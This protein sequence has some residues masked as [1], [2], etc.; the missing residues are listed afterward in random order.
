MFDAT[1]WRRLGPFAVA[2]F[3]ASEASLIRAAELDEVRIP[4]M[5]QWCLARPAAIADLADP[6]FQQTEIGQVMLAIGKAGATVGVTQF[7]VPYGDHVDKVDDNNVRITYCTNINTSAQ[8]P[9]GTDISPRTR[10]ALSVVG[11]SCDGETIDS[12]E[13]ELV[14][15]VEGD[16]WKISP[17]D[18][19]NLQHFVGTAPAMGPLEARVVAAVNDANSHLYDAQIGLVIVTPVTDPQSTILALGLP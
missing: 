13:D 1:L 6:S 14:A 4:A 9:M 12:C 3:I 17:S 11:K 10:P 5:T 18:V 15:G 16:P 7:G 19:G 8:P 2:L